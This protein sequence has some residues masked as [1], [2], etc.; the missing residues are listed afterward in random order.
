MPGQGRIKGQY[1]YVAALL[2]V[3][4]AYGARVAIDPLVGDTRLAFSIFYIAV[5]FSA[6]FAGGG[7]AA[8][9]AILSAALAYWAFIAPA[10]SMKIDLQALTSML[11]FGLTSVVDIYFITGMRRA[12]REYRAEQ[13]RAEQLAKGNADLFREFNERTTTHLQLVAALLRLRARDDVDSSYA[14]ALADASRR[15][16]MISR[17]HRNL[18]HGAVPLTDFSGFAR[19]L[20]A[21]CIEAA[22]NSN[23]RATVSG[24]EIFLPGEQATSMATILFEFARFAL[25]HQP[26][27]SA[28]TIDVNL[29]ATAMSYRLRLSSPSAN[30]PADQGLLTEEMT[31]QAVEAMTDHLHGHFTALPVP[32]GIAFE[33]NIPSDIVGAPQPT[34]AISE[35]VSPTLH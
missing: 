3:L 6:Y 31:R 13:L 18:N 20:L 15:T 2:F 21:A 17:V 24:D 4:L 22:P 34:F 25:R 12:L 35:P 11:F 27:E 30:I 1:R 7:P 10:Y 14:S 5:V 19:Q 16:L 23:I 26:A 28:G 33:L 8:L 32:Q 9:T 29:T